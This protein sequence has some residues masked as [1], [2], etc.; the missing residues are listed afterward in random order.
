VSVYRPYA[1]VSQNILAQIQHQPPVMALPARDMDTDASFWRQS[2][3]ITHTHSPLLYNVLFPAT[4]LQPHTMARRYSDR[5]RSSR[6]NSAVL[7]LAPMNRRQ[8]N[9]CVELH[10]L[11]IVTLPIK[12]RITVLILVPRCAFDCVHNLK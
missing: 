2:S 4:T 10:Y 6:W 5:I 11:R 9:H 12:L 7:R 3:A 8:N 1:I